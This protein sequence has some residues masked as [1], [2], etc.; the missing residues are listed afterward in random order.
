[1]FKATV[2]V[3]D[4]VSLAVML[5]MLIALLGSAAGADSVPQVSAEP[6]AG[7]IADKDHFRSEDE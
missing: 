3:N 2:Q 6:A 4:Y 1:M 5:L 7:F